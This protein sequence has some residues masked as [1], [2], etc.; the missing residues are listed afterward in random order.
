[1]KTLN[2]MRVRLSEIINTIK[3]QFG[4]RGQLQ[5]NLEEQRN[6]YQRRERGEVL[7]DFVSAKENI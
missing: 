2:S 3:R 5:V 6:V 7:V 1:M 4:T